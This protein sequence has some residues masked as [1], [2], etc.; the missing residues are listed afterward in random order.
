[1]GL[2]MPLL[3]PLAPDVPSQDLTTPAS[4]HAVPPRLLARAVLSLLQEAGVSTTLVLVR[5]ARTTT[6]LARTL[7]LSPITMV[8][9]DI[10]QRTKSTSLAVTWMLRSLFAR[11]PLLT[12]PR[13]R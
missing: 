1:M 4:R 5:T 9:V 3:A 2:A 6:T 11:V 10:L 13:L 8:L 7:M 12:T